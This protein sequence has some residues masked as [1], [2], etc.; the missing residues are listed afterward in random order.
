MRPFFDDRVA[1]WV[2][3]NIQDCGLGFGACRAMGVLDSHDKLVA[4]VVFHNWDKRSGV[5]EVSSAAIDPRWASRNVLSAAFAYCFDGLGCQSVVARISENNKRASRLW[6]ALGAQEYIIPRL[7][8]E[9]EAEAVYVLYREVWAN[10]KFR[11][12]LNG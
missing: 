8:G 9:H 5:I 12:I 1:N 11:S 7:R 3:Q 6:K 4:G 10:S 2:A